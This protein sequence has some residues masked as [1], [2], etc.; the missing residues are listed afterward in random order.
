[1]SRQIQVVELDL[2]RVLV[3]VSV[4][5]VLCVWCES[6]RVSSFKKC[7][8]AQS[9][10]TACLEG[11]GVCRFHVI[12]EVP[13]CLCLCDPYEGQLSGSRCETSIPFSSCTF[14]GVIGKLMR[15]IEDM[16]RVNNA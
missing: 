2:I 7:D 9:N 12:L 16:N 1:M 11:R 5:I 3:D 6:T 4:M 8:Q 10:A 15:G 13:Q 14:S